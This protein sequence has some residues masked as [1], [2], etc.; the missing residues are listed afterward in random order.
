[1]KASAFNQHAYDAESWL[2]SPAID[3]GPYNSAKL[4]FEHVYRYGNDHE[5][6]MTLWITTNYTGD[7]TTTQWSR[8]LIPVYSSGSNWT[9]VNSGEIDLSAY[10]SGEITIAF[11]YTSTTAGAATWEVKNVIIT[12]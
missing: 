12:E 4:Q 9:F 7:V 5:E 11:K 3:L 6:E 8:L 10:T 2:V 1:M